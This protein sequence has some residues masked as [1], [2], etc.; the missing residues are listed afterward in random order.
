MNDAASLAMER[1]D[2]PALVKFQRV[3]VED[4]KASKD[5]GRYVAKDV[6]YVTVTPLYG[7]GDGVIWKIPQW[8]AHL[9]QEVNAGRIPIQ[10]KEDYLKQYDRWLNGQEPS[11]NGTAIKGWGVISPA[12]QENLIAANILT[13][14]I[15]AG[16]TD[17]G[18]TRIGM[19]ALD[20]KRKAQA[21]LAQ[22]GDKGPLTMEVSALKNE[23]DQLK[24]SISS[25]ERQVQELTQAVRAQMTVVTGPIQAPP[26]VITAKDL[27]EDD[28]PIKRG[29]GRPRKEG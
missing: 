19:G 28:E 8:K 22:V 3:A 12:Q 14:E 23:N 1:K 29:P 18:M 27:L 17:E 4:K 13:V 24:G 15:L 5:A 2:L 9:D 16:I 10:W 25:L 11:P 20:L 26:A 21:W 7:K 6:D